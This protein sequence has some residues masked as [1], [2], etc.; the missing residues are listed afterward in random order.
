VGLNEVRE[1]H[2]QARILLTKGIDPSEHRK[3]NKMTKAANAAN[4]F[5]AVANELLTL[6]AKTLAGQTALRDRYLLDKCLAP[7]L[8]S[9]PVTEITTAELLIALR[10][11]ESMRTLRTAHNARILAGQ[12]FRYAMA[13]G[14][15]E[16]NPANDLISALQPLETGH[17]ASVTD[18]KQVGPLL[19]TLWSYP[20]TPSITAALKLAPLVFVR[21]NELRRAKWADI[22]L[23]KAEWRFMTSKT[24]QPHIVPLATQAVAILREL[25]PI[26]GDSAFVF[27]SLSKRERPIGEAALIAALRRM[28][29]DSDTMTIHGFRAMARTLLDEVLGFRPDYIEHQLG[30]VV[31]DPLGRAYNRTQHLEQRKKM[32]QAWADYLDSLRITTPVIAASV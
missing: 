13:T 4:R 8:G 31:R 19:R 26:T 24:G 12:I 2:T 22:D 28:D 25:Q 3:A 5:Q 15:V 6:R 1:R 11:I 9:R 27:P 14:R 29:F 17:F 10:K 23:D 32:M 16:R 18:P 30:H 7:Y 20:G 21:P